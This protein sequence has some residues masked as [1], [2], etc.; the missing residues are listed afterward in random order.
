[1]HLN[2]L[3][4]LFCFERFPELE[5]GFTPFQSKSRQ[6]NNPLF[7][8]E[9]GLCY[10]S[11]F[12]H[13]Q[14]L[15]FIPNFICVC[16]WKGPHFKEKTWHNFEVKLSSFIMGNPFSQSSTLPLPK[17]EEFRQPSVMTMMMRMSHLRRHAP[18]NFKWEMLSV[19]PIAIC[20]FI[21]F[22]NLAFVI[23]FARSF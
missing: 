2:A 10:Y 16:L 11:L 5:I 4:N 7:S 8:A 19:K 13:S 15:N 12:I 6:K 17:A 14:L 3:P 23:S 9:L 21:I 20:S 18:I 22:L 1:M